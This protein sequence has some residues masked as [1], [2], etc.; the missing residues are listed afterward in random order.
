MVGVGPT[1]PEAEVWGEGS[2]KI[3]LLPETM[4]LLLILR[5]LCGKI[6]CWEMQE[7]SL[8]RIGVGPVREMRAMALVADASESSSA[9]PHVAL[10][11]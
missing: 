2:P 8:L 5:H 7:N 10:R 3:N 4:H 9:T 1:L 11:T 6:Y